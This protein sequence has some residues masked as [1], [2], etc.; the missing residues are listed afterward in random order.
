MPREL[1][2]AAYTNAETVG[3]AELCLTTILAGLPPSFRVAVVA[4][5][6]QVAE[7]VAA[8]CGA[9]EISLV[10][11]P[12]RFWDA[13]AVAAHRRVLH[14]LEPDLCVV[15]L[16]TPYSG[17]HATAAAVSIPR[18]KVV[19]IEHLPLPSRSRG[20]HLLKRLTSRRLTAHVAVSEHTAD[21][22]AEEA[23]LRR[24][25]M[26]IVR[27]GVPEPATGTYELDLPR[28][29]VGGMGRLDRQKGF[30][31]LI[32]ALAVL[33][34]VSAVIA[35]EGP[36]RDALLRQAED[37]SVADRFLIVPWQE[38]VGPFLRSLDLFVLPSRY[39][40]LPLALLEAMATGVP[41]VAAEV[42]AIGE[43]AVSGQTAFLVPADD[44]QAL[45]GGIRQLLDD[46]EGRTRLGARAREAWQ[47]RFTAERMQQ[48]YA[49]LF[50][51]LLG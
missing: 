33:P 41:V 1:R 2:L 45:A 24:E 50:T 31:L 34:G 20:A 16:Q 37:L 25:R 7:A 22:T 21:A 9:A 19:A 3:G 10:Q 44:V 18:L 8:G 38:E 13:R 5:D 23:G 43:A 14:G 15:N 12:A 42:G 30:D 17:L 29:L 11:R 4:T 47:A 6:T 26:V 32:D 46:E 28:P 35:G 48:Q 49:D 36:E 51:R 40:G 39:E 27:N